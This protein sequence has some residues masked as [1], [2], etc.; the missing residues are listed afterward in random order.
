MHAGMW[1]VGVPIVTASDGDEYP[2]DPNAVLPLARPY[3]CSDEKAIALM[4]LQWH[5][6]WPE[7]VL[8]LIH[9]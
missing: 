5:N 1:S 8:S 7:L 2:T 3:M 9:I 6:Y 4:G